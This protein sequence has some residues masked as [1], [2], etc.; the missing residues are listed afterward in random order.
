MDVVIHQAKGMYP[1]TKL[2]HG[3]LKD[4]VET[5]TIFV[6]EK[7]RIASIA[8][9]NDVVDSRGIMYAGFTS[10]GGNI[11]AN[12]QMSSLTPKISHGILKDQIET[13][14][15]F[16]IEKNRIASIATE[17]DMVDSRWIMY[18]GFTSHGGNI[19]A[20]VQMSSLTPKISHNRS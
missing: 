1:A 8:T 3:I 20:N 15:I 5:V 18:A 19:T 13:V 11:T 10:H 17:N 12:V 9:E 16:V 7:N 2:L 14:T 4:Q 6:I